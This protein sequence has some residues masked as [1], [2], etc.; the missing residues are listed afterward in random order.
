MLSGSSPAYAPGLNSAEYVWN[1]EDSSLANGVS[2]N[3]PE[4]KLCLWT[5]TKFDTPVFGGKK[6]VKKLIK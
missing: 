1:Q 3:I 6:D 2:H 4:L 5:N